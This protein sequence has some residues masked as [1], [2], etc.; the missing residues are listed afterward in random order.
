MNDG[1]AAVVCIQN[2]FTEK[3]EMGVTHTLRNS[4]VHDNRLIF[5]HLPNQ[6]EDMLLLVYLFDIDLL[7]VV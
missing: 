7:L 3:C 6:E 2:H 1:N 4:G 5:T